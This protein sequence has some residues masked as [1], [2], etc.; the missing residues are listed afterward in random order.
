MA[1]TEGEIR[2]QLRF[3]GKSY[4]VGLADRASKQWQLACEHEGIDPAS[5]FIVFNDDN[6]FANKY[7]E[8]MAEYGE[9]MRIYRS[10]TYINI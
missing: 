1:L 6:P 9:A 7:N 8:I 3:Y 5:K 4:L 2:S 10:T